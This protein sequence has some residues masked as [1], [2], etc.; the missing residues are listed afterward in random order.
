MKISWESPSNIALIKYWGK[1]DIQIPLNPSISFTLSKCKTTTEV[2]FTKGTGIDI[3][4][5]GKDKP[6]FIP[7]IEN[8][9]QRIKER[10]PWLVSYR[11]QIK[12]SNSFPHS[13]GIAS[14][15]SGMS[16]LSLCIVEFANKI[17]FKLGALDFYQEASILSRLGSGSA[18]RSI[19]GGIAVWG[20]S[21]YLKN[22]RNEYA[23]KYPEIIHPIFKN[24]CDVIL[25]VDTKEKQVSS[26]LG[27]SLMDSHPFNEQRFSQAHKHVKDIKRI[28][29]TGNVDDFIQLTELEALTLHGLMMSSSPNFILIKPNTLKIIEKIREFRNNSKLPIS[30]TLDAGANVHLLFPNSAKNKTMEFVKNTL[31][32]FCR[33]ENF[34]SD[35]VGL[36]P[37]RLTNF[38]E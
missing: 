29:Q 28:L 9:L 7:K 21:S 30:F 3:S 10:H 26:T 19:Y 31:I 24:Y 38:E 22:S 6:E 15:A 2:H 27:H 32:Q 14:S 16:A 8:Y 1:R 17:G 5:D 37:K 11:L 4:L 34:I 35:H 33:G 36:G 25:I 23:I 12:T 20:E 13:S 18:S